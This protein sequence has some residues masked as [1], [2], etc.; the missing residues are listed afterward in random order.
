MKK[1]QI[2]SSITVWPEGVWMGRSRK[3]GLT[4]T[5][6]YTP[7]AMSWEPRDTLPTGMSKSAAAMAEPTVE[8]DSPYCRMAASSS[9]MRRYSSRAPDSSTRATP[10]IFSRAGTTS[11]S[12]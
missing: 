9:T 7:R 3:L 5:L 1:V 12:R 4:S 6:P 8:M 2:S 10:P 11:L